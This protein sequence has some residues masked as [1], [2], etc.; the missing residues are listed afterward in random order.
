MKCRP[1]FIGIL[2]VI[3]A[4]FLGATASASTYDLN[5]FPSMASS[6]P[7]SPVTPQHVQVSV[8]NLYQYPDT[9]SFSLDGPSG[10]TSQ[11][12]QNVIVSPGETKALD[13][14]L[15]NIGCNVIPGN[16]HFTVKSK[17]GTTGETQSK[18][19]DLEVLNC[20]DVQLSIDNKYKEVCIE[21][22]KSAVYYLSIDN[23]GKYSDTYTLS[24]SASWAVFSD[25]KI[26]V[27][28]GKM[29]TVALALFPPESATGLQAVNVEVSSQK[30]YAKDSD[31]VQLNLQDCYQMA[32]DL[33]P[34]EVSICLG[35]V[36]TQ[37]LLISNLGMKSDTYS[38]FVPNWVTVDKPVVTVS[39]KGTA[40]VTLSLKP[41]QKGKTFFNVTVASPKDTS[42][43]LSAVV[44]AD[45]CRGVA[46]IMSPPQL[47]VCQ[48]VPAEFMVSVKNLGTIQDTFNITATE[49]VPEFSKLSLNPGETREFKLSVSNLTQTGTRKVTI[50]AASGQITDSASSDITVENC[51]GASV[52][53]TPQE[54]S[55]CFGSVINYT[56]AIRNTGKLADTYTMRVESEL[57]SITRQV[58]LSA[59]E[60]RM[61]Y[62]SITVPETS[63]SKTYPVKVTINSSHIQSSASSTLSGK[64]RAD[65]YSVQISVKDDT[66]KVALCNATTVPVKVKN[67][68]ERLANFTVSVSGPS[69]VYLSPDSVQL[70]S[71][72]EQEVYLYFSPCFNVPKGVYPVQVSVSSPFTQAT[73]EIAVG[74]VENITNGGVTVTSPSGTG[75]PNVTV[76]GAN[77]SKGNV[78][79]W[80]IGDSN[81]WKVLAI[82]IITIIIIIILAIR[83]ILLA[84]K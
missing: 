65:C 29:K 37:K 81:T 16:Y 84:K 17:S 35:E 21:E 82:V 32:A 42:K 26:T 1:F 27:E 41:A 71:G 40:E 34:A 59:G 79:G 14:F 49:G 36:I 12:Q 10:F 15:I 30:F 64:S 73:K 78:T 67:T 6:C 44:T 48:T 72:Q 62:F 54:Q 33:Q 38:V 70:S 11:I 58:Q 18:S 74:V 52:D 25:N 31:T 57:A 23:R 13:L 4:L 3:A 8:K 47:S 60:L 24:A 43:T 39:P 7:C 5:V 66:S 76:P 20:Y 63:A 22:N 69:W 83:F 68:G 56:T 2:A 28:P 50:A 45:E 53:L 61:E 80:L 51:Y 75:G 77:A 19:L 46:V 55:A 9:F